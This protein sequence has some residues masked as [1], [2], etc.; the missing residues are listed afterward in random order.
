MELFIVGIEER[1][2][3]RI[4]NDSE[5]V[6]KLWFL[7]SGRGSLVTEAIRVGF[8]GGADKICGV[9]KEIFPYRFVG[10]GTVG[11][12]DSCFSW[13]NAAMGTFFVLFDICVGDESSGIFEWWGG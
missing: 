3:S 12:S 11:V 13:G 2:V 1:G 5:L 4:G 9:S 6:R 7:G 8:R 10:V